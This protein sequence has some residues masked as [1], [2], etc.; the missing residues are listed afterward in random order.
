M[1]GKT[2][3]RK[4]VMREII[5]ESLGMSTKKCRRG[6]LEACPFPESIHGFPATLLSQELLS[7]M[8]RGGS[9]LGGVDET[10]GF[11]S[12]VQSFEVEPI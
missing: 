4:N 6:A 10:P 9:V 11:Q 12:P 3:V 8:S 5:Q 7:E 1:K 2:T